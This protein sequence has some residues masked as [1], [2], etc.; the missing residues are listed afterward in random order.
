MFEWPQKK[1]VE[2]LSPQFFRFFTGFN[3]NEVIKIIR[4]SKKVT[5]QTREDEVQM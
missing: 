3:Q 5:E 2:N 1:N 4:I